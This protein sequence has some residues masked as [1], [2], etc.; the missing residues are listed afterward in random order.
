MSKG[1]I[2]VDEVPIKCKRCYLATPHFRAHTSE[3]LKW[4]CGKNGFDITRDY[5]IGDKSPQCPIQ[6][7]VSSDEAQ[8]KL[9]RIREVLNSPRDLIDS[10]TKILSILEE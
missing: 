7:E 6:Q 4:T 3:I 1:Y 10:N 9:D 2:T 5:E 8:S